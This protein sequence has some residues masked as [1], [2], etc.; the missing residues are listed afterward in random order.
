M[1][2]KKAAAEKKDT[3]TKDT[4]KTD[5]Q[6]ATADKVEKKDKSAVNEENIMPGKRSRKNVNYSETAGVTKKK[7][8]T[9]A[10]KKSG[11]RKGK[12]KKAAEEE[13]EEKKAE[14]AKPTEEKKAEE[15]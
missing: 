8:S 6:A 7:A 14:E 15:K 13:G 11:S 5:K 9:P 4:K 10:E 1:A 2:P 3:A 12:G